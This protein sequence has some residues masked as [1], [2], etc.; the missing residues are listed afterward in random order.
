ML[1]EF[2]V[3]TQLQLH[4]LLRAKEKENINEGTSELTTIPIA[5]I[6]GAVE[7]KNN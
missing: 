3:V 4:Y 5:A 7:R 2:F 1:G 6:I